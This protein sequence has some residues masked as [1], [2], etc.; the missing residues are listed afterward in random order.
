MVAVSG[1]LQPD[2]LLDPFRVKHGALFGS[3]VI[4]LDPSHVALNP[5]S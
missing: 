1:A 5:K 4:T 3:P 2:N